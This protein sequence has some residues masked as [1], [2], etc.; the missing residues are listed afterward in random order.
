MKKIDYTRA[1]FNKALELAEAVHNLGGSCN[2]SSA[3]EKMGKKLGGSFFA[4]VS[5]AVKHDLVTNRK[6]NLVITDK[7]KE[8]KLS[9]NEKEKKLHLRDAFLNVPLF[10]EIYGKYKDVKLPIEI[11]DKILIKEFGVSNK[12]GKRIRGYFVEGAKKVG[13][14]NADNTFN[15]NG[16]NDSEI[17]KPN[18]E[19]IY[20]K[21]N[22]RKKKFQIIIEG[23]NGKFIYN[24]NNSEEWERIKL[25]IDNILLLSNNHEPSASRGD[26]PQP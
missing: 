25:I 14:L 6:E 5:T 15:K 18:D 12:L 22:E 8:I 24:M 19:I 9:Y 20:Q 2:I 13:L 26:N 1:S 17:K 4:V 10:K 23:E 16:E 11:L 3:A 7:Y 21:S